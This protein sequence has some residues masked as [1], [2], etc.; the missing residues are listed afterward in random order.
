MKFL[1]PGLV[2]LLP[3]Y[4]VARTPPS[5]Y[6]YCAV[7][8]AKTY[9]FDQ[10]LSP[11]WI[12]SVRP[13]K[14]PT[15]PYPDGSVDGD[16]AGNV[17]TGGGMLHLLSHRVGSGFTGSR[18]LSRQRM[19][20]GCIEFV[21]RIPRGRG[22]WPAL[23]LRTPYDGSPINGE[24]DVLEGFGSHPGVL[25]ST[26]H[27]WRNGVDANGTHRRYVAGE[28]RTFTC[29]KLVADSGMSIVGTRLALAGARVT[30]TDRSELGNWL[31]ANYQNACS[32]ITVNKNTNFAE[33]FHKYMVVWMPGRLIWVL[34]GQS[35]FETTDEVPQVAMMIVMG[36]SVGAMDG[37]TDA[38]TP[39][40]G[41]L[42]VKSVRIME[43][44]H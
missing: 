24:I 13:V 8:S 21:A 10:G 7:D 23:W 28:D 14:T 33:D 29:A 39:D 25:V 34:D 5:P 17:Q 41:D 11:D 6:A 1:L 2:A 18:L 32:I 38:S 35:Y 20:Y 19:R 15:A 4:A 43:I 12:V 16:T 42:Q 36:L 31:F 40:L 27:H 9:R 30:G 3:A 44:K 26:L 22:L 37:G